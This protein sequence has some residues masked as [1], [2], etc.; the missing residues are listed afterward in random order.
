MLA[1]DP[2]QRYQSIHE[3]R[4]DL[5]RVRENLGQRGLTGSATQ[6]E[7]P[8]VAGRRLGRF[9][10]PLVALVLLAAAAGILWFGLSDQT[11]EAAGPGREIRSIALLPLDN[12]M[13][14][15]GQDYFVLGM[16]EAITIKLVART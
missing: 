12:L 9:G 13:N 7:R 4:T 6:P 5:A 2:S 11:Q 14:D 3:V 10:Y 1:R 15:P 8:R 16:A